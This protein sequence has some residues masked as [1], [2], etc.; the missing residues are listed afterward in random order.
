LFS[1]SRRTHLPATRW[2]SHCRAGAACVGAV[3]ALTG[4]AGASAHVVQQFGSYSIAIGWL[5]EPTYVGVENAV[6]VIVKDAQDKPVNDLPDGA[7]K[8]TVSTGSQTSGSMTLQPSFDPDTG[9]GT[10][11]EYDAPLIPT[12]PGVYTFHLTGSINGTNVS[13]SFTS[14]DKTFDDVTDPSAAGI[15]F[16]TKVPAISAVSTRLDRTG[17]RVDIAQAAASNARS[18]ASDAQS[19]ANRALVIGIVALIVGAI[20]GVTGLAVGFRRRVV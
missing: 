12:A 18:A 5:H 10:P 1:I 4:V 6:Q 13:Q 3:A 2:S 17:A 7:L 16:P 8:V 20:L 9:L 14:S 15:E 19:A 11:G